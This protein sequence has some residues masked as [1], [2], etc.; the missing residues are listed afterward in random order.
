MT[1]TACTPAFGIQAHK[2]LKGC[3]EGVSEQPS[4]LA[5]V[6]CH[7]SQ[8]FVRGL[9]NKYTLCDTSCC[10]SLLS[11]GNG[12]IT[13][14]YGQ[15]TKQACQICELAATTT[16]EHGRI[17]CLPRL[18]GPAT[19]QNLSRLIVK[20]SDNRSPDMR[21]AL[22]SSRAYPVQPFTA[23]SSLITLQAG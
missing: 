11:R 20:S 9:T 10:H 7:A 4:D 12:Q 18:R 16:P 21:G 22:Q 23:L 15:G 19:Q 13:L 3:G 8:T 17:S 1:A 6:A 14:L 5:M 2:V